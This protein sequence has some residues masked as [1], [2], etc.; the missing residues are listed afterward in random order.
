MKVDH[1]CWHM[2]VCVIDR[3]CGPRNQFYLIYM[4]ALLDT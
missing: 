4:V 1:P 2:H 3:M